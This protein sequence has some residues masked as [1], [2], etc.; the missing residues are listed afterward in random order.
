MK[1]FNF[2]QQPFSFLFPAAAWEALENR[3][4]SDCLL[5]RLKKLYQSAIIAKK[6]IFLLRNTARGIQ[7]SRSADDSKTGFMI[8][9]PS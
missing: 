2:M 6:G 3:S 1:F 9:I 5:V 4:A 8:G 7:K